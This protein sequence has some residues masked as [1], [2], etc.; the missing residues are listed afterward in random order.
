MSK[1]RPAGSANAALA[2]AQ[3]ILGWSLASIIFRIPA[4]G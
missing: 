3:E 1:T 2:V 4:K